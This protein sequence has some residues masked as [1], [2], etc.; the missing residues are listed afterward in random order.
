MV[1]HVILTV[2][3]HS[4]QG[5]VVLEDAVRKIPLK[6]SITGCFR[7]SLKTFNTVLQLLFGLLLLRNIDHKSAQTMRFSIY[8][9]Y[10][11]IIAEPNNVFIRCNHSVFKSMISPLAALLITEIN[12]LLSIIRMDVILPEI[13]LT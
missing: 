6:N 13:G 9:S 2:S 10:R 5:R 1:I 12:G 3:I 8:H 7:G 4:R 11:H